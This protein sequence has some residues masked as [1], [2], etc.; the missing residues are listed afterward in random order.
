MSVICE[1]LKTHAGVRAPRGD[2][3]ERSRWRPRPACT[4][5]TRATIT[6][7]PC[8]RLHRRQQHVR[9]RTLCVPRSALGSVCSTLLQIKATQRLLIHRGRQPSAPPTPTP[10]LPHPFLPEGARRGNVQGRADKLFGASLF[11]FPTGRNKVNLESLKQPHVSCC[12][13][14]RFLHAMFISLQDVHVRTF[15][16]PRHRDRT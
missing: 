13:W 14:E 3:S 11:D 10:H 15:S 6:V 4:R 8:Q 7:H 9:A 5:A 2:G 12:R 1:H 16:G